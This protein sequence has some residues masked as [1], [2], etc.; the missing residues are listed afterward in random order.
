MAVTVYSFHLLHVHH[1]RVHKEK[2]LSTLKSSSGYFQRR[3]RPATVSHQQPNKQ[4][5]CYLPRPLVR[6]LLL[7]VTVTFPARPQPSLALG[8]LGR[9][10]PVA[11]CTDNPLDC[12]SGAQHAD[13]TAAPD[14]SFC[15]CA[16]RE[17]ESERERQTLLSM[18]LATTRSEGHHDFIGQ[19]STRRWVDLKPLLSRA[20]D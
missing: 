18:Q 15:P 3:C 13:P 6:S 11:G 20:A 8:N 7:S 4:S 2:S 16:Q 1:L 12:L 19:S 9:C 5:L 10:L 17:S 14:V